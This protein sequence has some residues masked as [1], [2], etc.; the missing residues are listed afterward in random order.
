VTNSANQFEMGKREEMKGQ[1]ER[2]GEGREGGSSSFALGRKKKSWHLCTV[3]VRPGVCVC[4]CVCVCSVRYKSQREFTGRAHHDVVFTDILTSL[5][6]N[7][8]ADKYAVLQ[9]SCSHCE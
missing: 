1:E 4:V 3:H 2:R 7:R 9:W 8:L 6:N 5:L